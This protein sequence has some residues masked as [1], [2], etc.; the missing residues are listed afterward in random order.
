MTER[1]RYSVMRRWNQCN[2][3][4]KV[5]IAAE[6]FVHLRTSEQQDDWWQFLCKKLQTL[7]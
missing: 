5:R 1:Q 7:N 2:R 6:F 3:R 4:T